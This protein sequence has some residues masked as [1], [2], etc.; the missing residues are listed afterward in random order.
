MHGWSRCLE[1]AL[2][3]LWWWLSLVSLASSPQRESI[4]LECASIEGSVE[5]LSRV[6]LFFLFFTP[7]SLV[8]TSFSSLFFNTT[9]ERDRLVGSIELLFFFPASWAKSQPVPFLFLPE[10]FPL[11][12]LFPFLVFPTCSVE[13]LAQKDLRL[14]FATVS[15]KC[16]EHY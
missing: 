15:S 9:L 14:G 7:F 5:L 10:L 16:T 12:L 8:L 3:N 6:L 13:L 2:C 1:A 4:G 11:L